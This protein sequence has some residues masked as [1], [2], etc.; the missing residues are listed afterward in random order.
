MAV[1]QDICKIIEKFAPK[2]ATYNGIRDNVGLLIGHHSSN[3]ARILCCLDIT[4]AVVQEAKILNAQLIVSHHPV[5]FDRLEINDKSPSG[6]IVLDLIKNDISVYS[7]HTN[8]D[9]VKDGIND[10]IA[11]ILELQEKEIMQPYD[12]TSNSSLGRN[13][14]SN[15]EQKQ[16]LGR[17][18]NLKT[19]MSVLEFAQKVSSTLK[20]NCVRIVGDKYKKLKRVAVINGA[21][22]GDIRYFE[23]AIAHG[24][25]CI[26]TADVKHHVA[27]YAQE[28]GL[29]LIEPQHYTTEHPYIA[30]LKSKL[31]QATKQ[32]GFEIEIFQSLQDKNPRSLIV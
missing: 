3:V 6:R 10:Y 5:I 17:V 20:D 29:A 7:A 19:T 22:G 27:V 18:G 4:H 25:D 28:C 1:V 13:N 24:C 11:D 30:I 16:G 14:I 8:L 21:G 26:V 32:L 31:Q 9:F 15:E 23:M 12:T 2:D